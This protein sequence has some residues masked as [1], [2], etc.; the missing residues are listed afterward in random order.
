MR[1][2]AVCVCPSCVACVQLVQS[3][4]L[5]PQGVALELLY[6]P[7]SDLATSSTVLQELAGAVVAALPP[8]TPGRWAAWLAEGR[9][10]LVRG[11]GSGQDCVHGRLVHVLFI[12]SACT[13]L[14]LSFRLQLQRSRTSF[15]GPLVGACSNSR[16]APEAQVL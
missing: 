5:P 8:D 16:P 10:P 13:A 14:S 6:L 15:V 3:P 1:I 4:S 9:A 7:T 12:T 2:H 11:A